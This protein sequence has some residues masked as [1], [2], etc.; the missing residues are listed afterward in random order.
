MIKYLL[1]I[2]IL[3]AFMTWMGFW[4]ALAWFFRA[5][6]ILMCDFKDRPLLT[7]QLR[8]FS[9]FPPYL[10]IHYLHWTNY[11][12]NVHTTLFLFWSEM[13]SFFKFKILTSAIKLSK[14]KNLVRETFEMVRLLC[15]ICLKGKQKNEFTHKQFS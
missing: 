3:I 4:I 2:N 12:K 7:W 15:L 6:L 9:L 8:P 11:K 13:W 5:K 1:K 10:F 14:K